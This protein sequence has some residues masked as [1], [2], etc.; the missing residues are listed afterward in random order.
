MDALIRQQGTLLNLRIN[1][2]RPARRGGGQRG[3]VT[4]FSRASRLRLLDLFARMETRGIRTTFLTLTFHGIPTPDHAKTALKRFLMHVRYH[5][6]ETSG[7]WRQEFQERGAIHYHL[8]LFRLPYWDWKDLLEVW[9]RCTEEDTSGIFVKLISNG[10]R[11][12]VMSY[13]SKYVAKVPGTTLLGNVTYQQNESIGRQWGYIN[14]EALPFAEIHE[15]GIDGADFIDYLYH[16]G[17]R[18]THGKCFQG[19]LGAR[20]YLDDAIEV[21]TFAARHADRTYFIQWGAYSVDRKPD[22]YKLIDNS[23]I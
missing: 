9:T 5:Y 17:N 1:A 23:L 3:N 22:T 20:A 13:V 2:P 4:T 12:T 10:H 15:I 8:L 6:P 11:R 16:W 21:I 19:S 14:F 7:V 18:W